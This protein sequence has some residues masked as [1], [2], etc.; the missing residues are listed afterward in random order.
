ML[1]QRDLAQ[2]QHQQ[3]EAE[4]EAEPEEAMGEAGE[5]GERA[6]RN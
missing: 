5:I 2:R 4:E 3:A 6:G 1:Q